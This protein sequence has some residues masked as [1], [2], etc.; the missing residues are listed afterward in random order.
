MVVR[1]AMWSGPRTISTAMMRSFG[2]RAD[3]VVVDEPL[4]ACYLA[5]TG[6]DHPGRAEILAS[7]PT[8][9]D[10]V[11]AA[12]TGPVDAAVFYQKHMTIICCRASAA[13]GSAG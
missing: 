8:S 4:Y 10:A 7:Q 5:M 11:A 12:L 2:A 13:T 9:W 1:V 3:T 6:L